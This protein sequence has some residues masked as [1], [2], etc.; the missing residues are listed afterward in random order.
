MTEWIVIDK[1]GAPRFEH[2]WVNVS[3]PALESW[4]REQA[5][6]DIDRAHEAA[7]KVQ[8]AGHGV[9]GDPG[10]GPSFPCETPCARS[11][12]DEWD[13]VSSARML[14]GLLIYAA[15]WVVTILAVLTV[16]RWLL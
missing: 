8:R 5:I 13:G 9:Q 7:A 12:E 14:G 6:Y 10:T 2:G 4:G 11:I 16:K 15:L 3:K 1:P